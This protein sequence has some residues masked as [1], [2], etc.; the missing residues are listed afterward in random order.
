MT[1]QLM[2]P[3]PYRDTIDYA[4]SDGKS[5]AESDL[6]CEIMVYINSPWLATL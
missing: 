5:L 4:E 2:P 1:G 3:K 6:H